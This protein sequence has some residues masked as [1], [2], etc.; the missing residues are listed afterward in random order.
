MRWYLNQCTLALN[1]PQADYRETEKTGKLEIVTGT[2]V[3]FFSSLPFLTVLHQKSVKMRKNKPDR[4]CL[5]AWACVCLPRLLSFCFAQLSHPIIPVR[6]HPGIRATKSSFFRRYLQ[7]VVGKS[8]FIHPSLFYS[9]LTENPSVTSALSFLAS[10]FVRAISYP[11]TDYSIVANSATRLLLEA[12]RVEV[13]IHSFT[14]L[15]SVFSRF[16]LHYSSKS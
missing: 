13:K 8:N 3:F 9:H 2:D 7:Q 6:L 15:L 5:A 1:Q 12:S 14:L 16:L 4:R 11:H 10:A